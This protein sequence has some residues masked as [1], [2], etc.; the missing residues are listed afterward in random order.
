M[1]TPNASLGELLVVSI[2]SRRK[3]LSDQIRKANGLLMRLSQKGNISPVDGGNTIIEEITFAENSNAQWYQ[4]SEPLN[5]GQQENFTG[6]QYNWAQAACAVTVDGLEGLKNSGKE[7]MIP[8]VAS[9]VKVAETSL[10]NLV[11]QG[12]YSD[13]TGF[14]GKQLGGLNLLVSTSTTTGTVGGIPRS[15]NSWWQH[16]LT[17]PGAGVITAANINTHF[18]DLYVKCT[19][20][21]E[22]PD[23]G[24]LDNNLWKLYMAYLQNAQHF[25]DSKVGDLGFQSVKFNGMDLILDGGIGGFCPTNTGFF[26]N[27]DYIFFRPHADRNFVALSPGKRYSINQ[28]AEVQLIGFA[29][30]LTTSGLQ[31]QGRIHNN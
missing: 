20:G 5:M 12:L 10:R 24:V 9:R 21:N 28:D 29:G 31:L 3:A 16:Q 18:N 26:I 13:G 15:G 2:D 8:L 19:R 17:A 23:F 27:T 4:G 22:H 7:R 25:V 1:A 11:T 6:A 30:Q 14:G